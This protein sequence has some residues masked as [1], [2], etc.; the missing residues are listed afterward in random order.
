VLWMTAVATLAILTKAQAAMMAP[1]W[2]V[3]AI[4]FA[5]IQQEEPKT[6]ARTVARTQRGFRIAITQGV[7]RSWAML[8]IATVV[9]LIVLLPF[10]NALDG[11]LEAYTGAAGY[12]P[13]T[14][15]NGFSAWFL[16][17]PMIEPNLTATPLS[18]W[19]T[20]DVSSNFLGLTQR[21]WG[22]AGLMVVWG[23]V[24][25]VLWKR[26]C[27]AVSLR[28]AARLLP[29][30]FFVLSTQMHE[31]Y[32]FPAIAIWAWSYQASRRWWLSWIAI[33]ARASINVFW[34]WPGPPNAT[35]NMTVDHLLH[36]SWLG[37]SPGIWCSVCLIGVFVLTCLDLHEC[38]IRSSG[39]DGE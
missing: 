9:I 26:R 1:L 8:A 17:A 20:S 27:D 15:L 34:V 3:V 30:A 16:A 24:G 32:L 29:L 14:H 18:A 13:F 7:S 25:V 4:R 28:K 38:P 19:Y 35:W 21:A 31:R 33:A 6:S 37:L 2:L 39:K 12:Y 10:R 22:L 11:V 23:Y 5:L 36:R